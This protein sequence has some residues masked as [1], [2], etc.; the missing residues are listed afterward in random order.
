MLMMG[1]SLRTTLPTLKENLRPAWPD[2]EKVREYDRQ[3]K[4]SYEKFYNRRFSTKPLPPL[5]CGDQV[6]LKI[7]G[8][9]TWKTTAVVQH[10]EAAPRS[11]TLQTD[12]GDTPRRNRRC[13]QLVDRESPA[14]PQAVPPEP[15]HP[16]AVHPELSVTQLVSSHPPAGRESPVVTRSGRVV[17]PNRRY[18]I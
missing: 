16:E 4:Q 2:L 17:K 13:I 11:F 6:R 1:R 10:E 8:E 12:R 3:A 5:S 14:E 9:K 7:D 15:V 18:I